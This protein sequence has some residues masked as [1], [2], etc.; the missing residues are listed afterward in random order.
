MGT[1]YA[2]ELAVLV[3]SNL[4]GV[5]DDAIAKC[6]AKLNF[7]EAQ[8]AEIL[9]NVEAGDSNAVALA[10]ATAAGAA[11]CASFGPLVA[12]GCGTV[13]S[14]VMD[15]ILSA[16]CDGTRWAIQEHT[17]KGYLTNQSEWRNVDPPQ[18][19]SDRSGYGRQ[20]CQQAAMQNRAYYANPP[21]GCVTTVYCQK[22]GMPEPKRVS[23][24]FIERWAKGGAATATR[25]ASKYP[26]GSITAYDKKIA[27]W[28]IAAPKAALS[29]SL[30]GDFAEI[31]RSADEPTG[32]PTVSYTD[33]MR[34]TGQLPWYKDW[35][36]YAIVG[37][38]AAV[39]AGG[40]YLVR[41]SRR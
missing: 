30:S 23:G 33:Y 6:Q 37:S 28:R 1:D 17:G 32:V 18:K 21:A 40:Y 22:P 11:A 3:I 39:G 12:A 31:A 8:C 2:R 20:T 13:A 16:G 15:K 27:L 41:R 34:R 4:G 25:A 7:T 36:T 35:R 24:A 10:I 14:V 38:V 5:R 26:A 29:G 9:K 19:M